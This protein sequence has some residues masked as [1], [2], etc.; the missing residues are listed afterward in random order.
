M[1]DMKTAWNEVGDHFSALCLKL[2]LHAEEGLSDSEAREQ[3]GVDRLKAAL[4]EALEAIGDAYK[5]EAVRED[6]RRLGK[7]FVSA[8]DATVEDA[9][10]RVASKTKH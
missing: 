10:T 9:R 3:A 2:K 7:S 4:D 1:D 8:V 5:D 6:A